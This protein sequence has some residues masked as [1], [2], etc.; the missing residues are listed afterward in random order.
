MSCFRKLALELHIHSSFPTQKWPSDSPL[1]GHLNIEQ[2]LNLEPFARYICPMIR[3]SKDTDH[4]ATLTLDMQGRQRNLLNHELVDA[5]QPVVEHLE[6]EKAAGRLKGVIIASAKDN[7]LV[8]G[9]LKYLSQ[10]ED[11]KDIFRYSEKLKAFFRNL[12]KPG[13]PVVAAINGNALGTGFELAMACHYRIAL[14]DPDIRVGLPEA[15]YGVMPGNGGTI[16]LL[17]LLGIEK[18][19]DV[20]AI[21]RE[22]RPAEAKKV[23]L[24]DELVDAEDELL[25]KAKKYL[26]STT[27]V[28]RPWDM[29]GAT[30]PGGTTKELAGASLIS[31]LAAMA[32][33]RWRNHY[34]AP[35]AI[36]NTLNEG[37][38]V[39][40]ETACKIESR[41]YTALLRSSESKNMT[42]ALWFDQNDIAGGLSRPK[43]FGKFRPRK[44]GIVG[45]GM[46]GSGIA[47]SCLIS[48]LEVVLKDVSNLIAEQGKEKISRMLDGFVS[49]GTISEAGKTDC[50]SRIQTTEDASKFDECDLVIESVFENASVKKKVV[51]EA[52]K[53]LDE[54]AFLASNTVS[55]PITKLAENSVRPQQFVGLH[56]F[57]PVTQKPLVEIVRGAKTNEETVAR[58]FDFVK[59]IGKTP[60]VVKDDWGFY[61]ARVQNTFIL[62][63]ITMLKEGYP[64][65]L[66]E[67][68]SLQAGMPQGAL[69]LADMLSLPLVLRYEK[70]AADHYGTRYIQ[71]PAVD[72]LNKM[73]EKL[74]RP[75]MAKQAG[76]YAYGENGKEI[77]TGLSEHFPSQQEE[78]DQQEIIERFLFAQVLEAAWCLQEGVIK[79]TQEANLGS[80]FGW[81]FP[82][83][84]GGVIQYVRDFGKDK[85]IARAEEL[86]AAHGQRFTVPRWLKQVE[87]LGEEGLS[88][89][90]NM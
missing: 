11:P 15:R 17:W 33:A 27:E 50:M 35:L 21:G 40:F 56:F 85:F 39:D 47:A 23:S 83:F 81:G 31:R 28:R 66:I 58:A 24:I 22:W 80:V 43:G 68:L 86:K 44:V 7:W 48:G 54:Y 53:Q 82:A 42:Q 5:F 12:E 62:E 52:E 36:L 57:K 38:Q 26:M 2:N 63:G 71:H 87:G 77:W 13:V 69:A 51:A 49:T 34:P 70:Q 84:R 72:V 20:L 16:R 73:M 55:I 29:P 41:Y 32:A 90:V 88:V 30:V 1:L 75:G 8:G 67:N 61:V 6:K 19:F 74:I 76:F 45:A 59:F 37:S 89:Q 25:P 18:A 64:P 4:I 78:F 10:V 79:T 65:A 14:N 46:M 60:I 3:Y 9:D